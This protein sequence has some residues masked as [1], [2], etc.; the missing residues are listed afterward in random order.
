MPLYRN[1]LPQLDGSLFLTDAG[2]E[3]DLIF[4]H[5][6]ELRGFLGLDESI[7]PGYRQLDYTVRIG[8]GGT[9]EQFREIHQAVMKTSPNFFNLNQ[10]I[11]MNGRL[12]V[13]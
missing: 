5:G 8:G 7:P 12:E 3:T 2:L 13:V 9:A 1:A 4:N 11:C 6:I 10:P